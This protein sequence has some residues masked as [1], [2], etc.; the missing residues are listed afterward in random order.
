MW[1]ARAH[2]ESLTDLLSWVC[3]HALPRYE[4]NP[5]HIS[6]EVF[7]SAD[8]RVVVV[9]KWRTSPPPLGEPPKHLMVREP[10]FWDFS[11]V[12]R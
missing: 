1:E 3:D 6:S 2:P 5:S 10:H 12:D 8:H 9:S 4:H 11:P 7:S